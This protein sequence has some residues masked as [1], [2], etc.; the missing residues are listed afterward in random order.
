MYV[1]RR[2]RDLQSCLDLFITEEIMQIVL[3]C[4][5]NYGHATITPVE[6]L[7]ILAGVYRCWDEST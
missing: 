2:I 3:D 5:N 6:G 7:L 1:L 4:M